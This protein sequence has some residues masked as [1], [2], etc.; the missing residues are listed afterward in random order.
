VANW[1]G[2]LEGCLRRF[3]PSFEVEQ[4]G[5]ANLR[6]DAE[7]PLCLIG[8]KHFCLSGCLTNK[9]YRTVNVAGH[10]YVFGR[11]GWH[12]FPCFPAGVASTLEWSVQTIDI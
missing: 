11:W 9:C 4:K 12:R 8:V 1:T 6:D 10:L 5:L 3:R 2:A 7:Q